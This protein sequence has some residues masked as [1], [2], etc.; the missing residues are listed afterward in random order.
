MDR[1]EILSKV[2]ALVS[3]TI[4]VDEASVSETTSFADLGADSFDLLELITAFED[5]F[6][7]TMADDELAELKTVADVID[8]IQKG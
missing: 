1:A 4:E 7:L 6:G 5:E 2:A 8:A 3:E